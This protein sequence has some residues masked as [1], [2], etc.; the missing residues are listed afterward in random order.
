M[1]VFMVMLYYSYCLAITN[2][3][4]YRIMIKLN[5]HKQKIYSYTHKKIKHT[6]KDITFI[7]IH[8][9]IHYKYITFIQHK[10]TEHKYIHATYIHT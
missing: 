5:K 6:Y 7:Q 8:A 3:K 1:H 4:Y 9:Y 2:F 10:Y